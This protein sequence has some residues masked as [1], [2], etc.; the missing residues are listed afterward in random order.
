[1]QD[2]NLQALKELEDVTARLN[3][4]SVLL[5]QDLQHIVAALK[6]I[7][8][9]Q[10]F[11]TGL[12][13]Q[14]RSNVAAN[15][16]AANRE[17]LAEEKPDEPIKAEEV[18]EPASGETPVIA[19]TDEAAVYHH[20]VEEASP[21]KMPTSEVEE[22]AAI[23][24]E[25]IDVPEEE[26]GP[27]QK[28]IYSNYFNSLVKAGKGEVITDQKGK[29]KLKAPFKTYTQDV[30]GVEKKTLSGWPSGFYRNSN[31]NSKMLMFRLDN[32][33]VLFEDIENINIDN[34]SICHLTSDVVSPWTPASKIS[35]TNQELLVAAIGTWQMANCIEV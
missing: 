8:F 30:R 19:H 6:D 5:R 3:Q 32:L 27:I 12:V 7:E 15:T 4:H 29:W 24:E 21:E 13:K 26:I 23:L 2:T 18:K 35:A 22:V 16:E 28:A 11:F 9:C 33:A 25:A 31:N 14:A 17:V 1:M 20:P 10:N 34:I